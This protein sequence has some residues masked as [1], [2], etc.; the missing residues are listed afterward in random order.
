MNPMIYG[1]ATLQT[2]IRQVNRGLVSDMDNLKPGEILIIPRLKRS[3]C[4][5]L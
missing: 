4:D 5:D 3:S 1:D 2:L